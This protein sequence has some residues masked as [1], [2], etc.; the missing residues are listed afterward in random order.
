MMISNRYLFAPDIASHE[1]VMLPVG[2]STALFSGI[3]NFKQGRL[4]KVGVSVAVAVRLGGVVDANVNVDAIVTTSVNSV[5]TI[6]SDGNTLLL[7]QNK[8]NAII[9]NP[10]TIPAHRAH[11]GKPLR[12][13]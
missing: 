13:R 1:K 6:A 3:S 4:D 10:P 5:G 7:S 11:V 8:A 9:N 2:C 12:R